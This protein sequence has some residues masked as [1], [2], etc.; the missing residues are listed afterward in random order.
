MGGDLTGRFVA[1][2][3]VDGAGKTTQLA[4]LADA[5]RARGHDVVTVREPGGTP[6][7]E[8]LR[9]VLL[10][11]GGA[12]P[13]P[14]AEVL[15]FAAARAQLVAEVIRPALRA[16]RFV[17]C[18]R[19]VDS[20][21]AYQGAARGLGI[22]EVWRANL[23]AVGDCLPHRAVVLDVAVA[24]AAAR[25]RGGDR[26]EGEG[27]AFQER[28]AAGYREVARRFPERVV[29]VAAAG[30]PGEVHAAVMRSLEGIA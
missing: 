23:L 26:I 20:S 8:R 30:E 29:M 2:E 4:L 3:G 10:H 28:V 14:E 18:D 1:L 6:L 5:L 25:A 27:T 17:L 16:G 21:L 7:G 22:D 9:D 13:A 19:F 11:P 12:P 24:Q 15:L